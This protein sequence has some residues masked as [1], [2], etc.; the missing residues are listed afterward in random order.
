L[1]NSSEKS[2]KDN[3]NEKKLDVISWLEK[4]E[5][6]VDICCNVRLAHS[7]ICIIGN[8]ADRMKKSAKSGTKVSAKRT[9]SGSSTMEHTEKMLSSLPD[10]QN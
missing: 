5:W 1:H 7:I 9:Y 4:G 3:H 10:N 6:T 8:S 2:V